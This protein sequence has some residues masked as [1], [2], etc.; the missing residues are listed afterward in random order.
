MINM[1][2]KKQDIFIS[3]HSL[4]TLL[5]KYIGT[6][7]KYYSI[8]LHMNTSRIYQRNYQFLTVKINWFGKKNCIHSNNSSSN[9]K[10]ASLI[11][12]AQQRVNQNSINS[13]KASFLHQ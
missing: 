9:S 11:M 2:C 12:Q 5:F 4:K 7:M 13:G 10:T 1:D 6:K 8:H 3:Y